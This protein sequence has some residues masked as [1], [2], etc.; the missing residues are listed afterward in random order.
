MLQAGVAGNVLPQ[1]AQLSI[2]FRLLPGSTAQDALAYVRKWLGP[3]TAHANLS[4]K[5]TPFAP[6]AV[7]DD[8]GPAFQLITQ[9][10]QDVWKFSAAAGAQH[11][12]KGV[13]VLPY[14][15]PGGTDSKHYHY[16]NLTDTI[17]RFCPFSMKK[18]DISR[19]HAS[20]ERIGVADVGRLCCTYRTA[21]RLVGRGHSAEGNSQR[22]RQPSEGASDGAAGEGL[23][24][25]DEL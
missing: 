1:T 14:L 24:T 12:G 25:F 21:L 20:N 11:E 5:L 2:N 23:A 8:K 22:Q 6:S 17:L 19:I 13:P 4:L 18:S 3:N 15:V 10:I 16:H 9:A 7:S